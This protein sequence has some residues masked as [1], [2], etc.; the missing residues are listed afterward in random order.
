MDILVDFGFVVP[1]T[2]E[3]A[4][5]SFQECR[6]A[7]VRFGA[8]EPVVS[9]F[10]LFD[11]KLHIPCVGDVLVANGFVSLFGKKVGSY[12]SLDLFKLKDK[13]VVTFIYQACERFPFTEALPEYLLLGLPSSNFLLVVHSTQFQW[14]FV[15]LGAVF[16]GTVG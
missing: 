6:L 2:F 16:N 15:L 1:R 4:V 7:E 9:L 14:S 5:Q 13:F 3:L 12:I 11:R 8:P 10:V